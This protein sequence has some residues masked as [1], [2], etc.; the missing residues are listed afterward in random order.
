M[1]HVECNRKGSDTEFKLVHSCY[2]NPA[3]LMVLASLYKRSM[4]NKCP[5]NR[6]NPFKNVFLKICQVHRNQLVVFLVISLVWK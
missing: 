3:Q 6:K 1:H 2:S 5:R 4:I